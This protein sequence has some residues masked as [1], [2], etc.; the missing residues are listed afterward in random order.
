MYEVLRMEKE[1][2]QLEVAVADCFNDAE[3]VYSREE[4]DV[5]V[6]VSGKK[7]TVVASRMYEYLPVGFAVLKKLAVVFGTENFEV[8]NWSSSG[9][10]TCDY[11][12][13]YTHE[14]SFVRDAAKE[15][16]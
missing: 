5:K 15:A 12:S 2:T 7:V 4:I 3:G 10:E 13:K 11:G 9:C 16:V 8:N 14:F 6:S 1:K